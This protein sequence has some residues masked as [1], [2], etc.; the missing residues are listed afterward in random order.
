KRL[1]APTGDEGPGVRGS[2]PAGVWRTE[3]LT[4]PNPAASLLQVHPHEPG[5]L[6]AHELGALAVD[7][8]VLLV[9]LLPRV[10]VAGRVQRRAHLLE[11]LLP[12]G[13]LLLH[14]GVAEA[15]GRRDERDG[16]ADD[17]VELAVAVDVGHPD[18]GRVRRALDVTLAQHPA[19]A[20][21]RV[22]G[23]RLDERLER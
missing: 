20:S 8:L 7:L 18:P 11:R 22:G 21:S 17:Q 6:L 4:Y 23:R 1:P 3:P 2:L 14:L 13:V 12:L 10:V 19:G 15:V 5:H 16:V 9:R